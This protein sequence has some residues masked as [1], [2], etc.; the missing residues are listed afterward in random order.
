MQRLKICAVIL[1]A[2]LA[3]VLSSPEAYNDLRAYYYRLVGGPAVVP[4]RRVPVRHVPAPKVAAKE[5]AARPPNTFEIS[6]LDPNIGPH[7]TVLGGTASGPGLIPVP[8]TPEKM[9]SDI[10]SEETPQS[11]T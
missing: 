4:D 3:I 11:G 5:P 10:V 1:V 2:L 6:G 8:E 9:E 7:I